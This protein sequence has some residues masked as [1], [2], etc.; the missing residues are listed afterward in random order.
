MTKQELCEL[1]KDQ[2]IRE[3]ILD[4]EDNEVVLEVHGQDSHGHFSITLKNQDF[5]E[6]SL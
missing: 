2:G 3:L 5:A 1:L 6:N 4:L